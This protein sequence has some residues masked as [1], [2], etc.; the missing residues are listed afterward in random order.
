MTDKEAGIVNRKDIYQFVTSSIGQR[1]K[2]AEEKKLLYKERPFVI[3]LPARIVKSQWESDEM[4]LVQGI[5]DAYFEEEGQLVLVDYKTDR[6]DDGSK[7]VKKYREQLL[8]YQ[9]ALE[10]VTGKKVK[11][12][13]IY[14]VTLGEEWKV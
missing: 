13:I 12:K 10:Q 14:S 5:I 3:G 8:Y 1:M 2:E 9:K 7:L 4:I 11:E 6:V